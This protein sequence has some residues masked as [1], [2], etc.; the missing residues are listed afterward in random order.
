MH[1][2][3]FCIDGM[4][5]PDG[6]PKWASLAALALLACKLAATVC[7]RRRGAIA[8]GASAS[9][10]TGPKHGAVLPAAGTEVL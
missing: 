1:E 4:F 6:L 5:S 7:T 3:S 2:M 10:S 8:T 9:C